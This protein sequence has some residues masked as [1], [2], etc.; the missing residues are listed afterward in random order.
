MEEA[1]PYW[2]ASAM[3]GHYV[4]LA[5][6]VGG[7]FLVPGLLTRWAALAQIPIL[8]GAIFIVHMPPILGLQPT[9][10]LEMAVATLLVL[11]LTFL[12]GAGRLSL[13]DWLECKSRE[14]EPARRARIRM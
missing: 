4:M 2:F 1:G 11:V 5:H 10:E 3:V 13:D 7:A 8:L 14:I 9:A 12:H 6:L